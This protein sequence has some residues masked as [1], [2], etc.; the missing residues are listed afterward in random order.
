MRDKI[1]NAEASATT[2]VEKKTRGAVVFV[3]RH[4]LARF[5]IRIKQRIK[6]ERVAAPF[7]KP[8]Q[9]VANY[10]TP[11]RHIR[12]SG[13]F[14]SRLCEHAVRSFVRATHS[15]VRARFT[16]IH[17]AHVRESEW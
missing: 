8:L 16:T 6:T 13:I 7:R 10:S 17:T 9:T 3:A 15:H 4:E 12:H 2:K 11:N 14:G 1:P 5:C